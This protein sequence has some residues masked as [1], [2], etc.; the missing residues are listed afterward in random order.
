MSQL[1]RVAYDLYG[2]SVLNTMMPSI[3]WHPKIPKLFMSD[4]LTP[5]E[6]RRERTE[7]GSYQENPSELRLEFRAFGRAS[8]LIVRCYSSACEMRVNRH[9]AQASLL[10]QR[11]LA[12]MLKIHFA[13]LEI[14]GS[15]E[16]FPVSP[17]KESPRCPDQQCGSLSLIL[18]E[19]RN[20]ASLPSLFASR[21]VVPRRSTDTF[22]TTCHGN[23]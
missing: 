1:G 12:S 16:N 14:V 20:S 19:T 3:T 13:M 17:T 4:I 22:L 2:S 8:T 9:G 6:I 21:H 7:Q 10:E 18:F 23:S 5:L 15:G 11:V